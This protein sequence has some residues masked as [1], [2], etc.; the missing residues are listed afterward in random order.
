MNDNLGGPPDCASIFMIIMVGSGVFLTIFE[1]VSPL[2]TLIV[3]LSIKTAYEECSL[4]KLAPKSLYGYTIFVI[5]TSSAMLLA[6]VLQYKYTFKKKVQLF[7]FLMN[8]IYSISILLLLSATFT[9]QE[10]SFKGPL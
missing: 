3:S 7:R 8:F 2:A 10:N 5:I 9:S 1:I 4:F 6:F